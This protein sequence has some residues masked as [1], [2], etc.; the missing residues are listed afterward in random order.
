MSSFEAYID[1][2]VRQIRYSHEKKEETLSSRVRQLKAIIMDMVRRHEK[3][4]S[5][6]R[7]SAHL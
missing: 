7:W 5:A 3:L 1:T 6:Y 4:L 2:M